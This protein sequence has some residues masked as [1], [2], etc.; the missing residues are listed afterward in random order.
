MKLSLDDV[1]LGEVYDALGLSAAFNI[2][3]PKKSPKCL[4]ERAANRAPAEA[5]ALLV[6]RFRGITV[7]D[8]LAASGH[9]SVRTK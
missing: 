7:A 4:H 3:H 1:T 6:S 9:K 2:A 5:E 8:A